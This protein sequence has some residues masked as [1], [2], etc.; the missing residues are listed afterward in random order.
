VT[1]STLWGTFADYTAPGVQADLDG[2]GKQDF[3]E[4]LPDAN[5][6]KSAAEALD[7]YAGEL[8]T[9]AQSWEPTDSE[10]FSALVSNVPTVGDFFE[11]WMSSRFVAGDAAKQRD[12]AVISRLSDI[13]D[14]VSSWQVIYQGLSTRVRTVDPSQDAQIDQ[15]LRDLK[16]FVGDIYTKEQ[17]G[18]HY[19]PEEAD[20]LSAEAQNRATAIAGQITQVAAQLNVKIQQ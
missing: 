6:L 12:F 10:A 20:L 7:R 4:T 8:G 18:K 17:G 1:E 19:T 16:T 11:S 15:G 9:K 2:N 3:G 5:V 13:V 14:N